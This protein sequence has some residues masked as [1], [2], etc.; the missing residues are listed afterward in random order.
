[1]QEVRNDNWSDLMLNITPSYQAYWG[2]TKVLKTKGWV[3]THAFRKSNN[4]TAFDY[5]KKPECLADS[6]EQQC[7]DNPLHHL[8]Y[9]H[10]VEEEDASKLFFDITSSHPNSLLI[11]A[12]SCEPPPSHH[13]YRRPRNILSDPSD[14]LTVEVEKL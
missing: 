7:S 2:L 1:M 9:T 13:F 5:R 11:S 14:D 8:E 12:V 3:P 6:I 4:S 10:R